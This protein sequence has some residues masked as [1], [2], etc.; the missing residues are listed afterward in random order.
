MKKILTMLTGLIVAAVLFG[1][2]IYAS[3]WINFEGDSQIEESTEDV[4]EILNILQRVHEG[5]ITAEE[6][7][8]QLEERVQ[9]LE[10]MNPSGL[11][12]QNKEL[13]EQVKGLESDLNQA[14]IDLGIANTNN[15]SL[16]GQI[17]ELN[18]TITSLNAQIDTL[19]QQLTSSDEYVSHLE[20]ELERANLKVSEL[21]TH[22]S[23]ALEQAREY[24]VE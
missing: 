17:D 3:S 15:A 18:N 21:N 5:K 6:A 4:D 16:Q 2:G 19:E 12:K 11:A 24:D 7:V 14:L 8:E 10:D 9:E 23:N 22:T 1:A 20:K 13:R